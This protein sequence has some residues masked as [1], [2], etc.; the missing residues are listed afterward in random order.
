MDKC[1]EQINSA[2]QTMTLGPH[3]P[4]EQLGTPCTL[5]FFCCTASPALG[6]LLLLTPVPH[7][8]WRV[9]SLVHRMAQSGGVWSMSM[10]KQAL[11]PKVRSGRCTRPVVA[12]INHAVCRELQRSQPRSVSGSVSP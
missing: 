3:D 8:Y 5:P 10:S 2:R 11:L 7:V 6:R 1:R 4:G 12:V 9:Q